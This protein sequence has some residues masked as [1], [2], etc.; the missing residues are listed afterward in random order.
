MDSIED[1]THRRQVHNRVDGQVGS[2]DH[3]SREV[4]AVDNRKTGTV[5]DRRI[6]KR[7][8]RVVD[9]R[10]SSRTGDRWVVTVAERRART[11]REVR[12]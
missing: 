2:N 9:N 11:S 10:T 8:T 12:I 7:R 6:H 4:V 1:R 3:R 5:M